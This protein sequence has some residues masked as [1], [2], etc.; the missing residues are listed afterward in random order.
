MNASLSVKYYN[1]IREI[2]CMEI[3]QSG[4]LPGNVYNMTIVDFSFQHRF[5]GE[6]RAMT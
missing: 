2:P 6:L 3:T 1:I 5:N 4:M